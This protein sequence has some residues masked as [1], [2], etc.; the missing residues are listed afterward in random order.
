MSRPFVREAQTCCILL[1][2]WTLK[3]AAEFLD[4]NDLSLASAVFAASIHS[5]PIAIMQVAS[6][7]Q[8]EEFLLCFHGGGF[9]DV[10]RE[11]SRVWL[12]MF[13]FCG[14][15][16]GVCGRVRKKKPD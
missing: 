13:R 4:K 15:V 16:W 3:T 2:H 12:H 14:R 11:R 6:V 1:S 10:M 9:F 8:K 7:M 5:F